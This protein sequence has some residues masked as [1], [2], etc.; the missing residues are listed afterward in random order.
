MPRFLA[1]PLLQCGE[2]PGRAH[3]SEIR[4]DLEDLSHRDAERMVRGCGDRNQ[5]VPDK[6]CRFPWR[7]LGPSLWPDHS[8]R[9]IHVLGY[10]MYPYAVTGKV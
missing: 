7:P 4:E 6:G 8:V 2:M 9:I 10:G 5:A 3:T 1:D